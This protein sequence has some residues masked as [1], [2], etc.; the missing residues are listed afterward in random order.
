[1]TLRAA[2]PDDLDAIMT[3]ERRSFPTDAWSAQAMALELGSPHGRYLVDEHE[4]SVVGYGGV[5]ALEGSGDA[6]IQTI[7]FDA[8]HRG[9]GR[10][11]A[12][13]RALLET[14][15]ERGAREVFLEVRADNPGAEGLYRSEGFEEIGRRPRYYQPDDVDAIVM[16]LVLQHRRGATTDAAKEATA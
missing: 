7:A 2:T 8:E 9:A 4:G 16:R 3:I 10:G 13:L 11:R 6:D 1:M 14:A 15:A 5:R 12:L